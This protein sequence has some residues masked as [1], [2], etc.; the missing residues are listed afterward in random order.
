MTTT[1]GSWDLRSAVQLGRPVEV[2][3]PRQPGAHPAVERGADDAGLGQVRLQRVAQVDADGVADDQDAQRV[4]RGRVLGVGR[5]RRRCRGRGAAVLGRRSGLRP[6]PS[7]RLPA[8]PWPRHRQAAPGSAVC[9]SVAAARD[10]DDVGQLQGAAEGGDR[11]GHV[12]AHGA[13]RP[14]GRHLG[15]V[16]QG[17]RVEQ[18][19]EGEGGDAEHEDVSPRRPHPLVL[20]RG[21][22]GVRV[23]LELRLWLPVDV[24]RRYGGVAHQKR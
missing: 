11:A 15:V 10:G 12:E 23:R 16:L 9:H 24:V 8:R 17:G 4:G 6:R 19:P 2:V 21:E 13:P 1:C 22:L 7:G 5:H 14:D 20:A 3:G 18:E